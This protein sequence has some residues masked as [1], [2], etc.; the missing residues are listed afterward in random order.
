VP[1][2]STCTEILRRHGLLD[3]GD[4][5]RH[6][7][8][9]RFEAPAPNALWQLDFKGDVVLPQTRVYPLQVLDDHARFV[10][11]VQACPDQRG[12]TVRAVLTAVFRTY[13]LPQAILTDNGP[14]WG[15]T[16]VDGQLTR[17][18][19]WWARLHIAVRH[20]RPA[21]PQTQG[22]VERSLRTLQ[23]EVLRGQSY[24]DPTALQA[25]FETW[26]TVYNT[27]RPHEALAHAT[28]ASRYRPSPLA[29]PELL[30]PI[31]YLPDDRV[32]RVQSPRVITLDGRTYR[33]GKALVGEPVAVRP[34]EFD[35]LLAVYY[36]AHR[37]RVFH[38]RQPATA[39]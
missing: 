20:G 25:A 12:S 38:L 7:P 31:L 28:P 14:P 3:P 1:S 16:Q 19:A 2:P 17:L 18:S 37:V 32:R 29:F 26:R 22:K 8:L 21:H 36:I 11:A 30:L 9:Q 5:V 15:A 6:R 35:G 4:A 33:I 10:L 39:Y 34:T 13:G 27:W 23:A 24:A